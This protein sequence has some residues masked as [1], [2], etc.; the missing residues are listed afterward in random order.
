M[1]CFAAPICC[2]SSASSSDRALPSRLTAHSR[3]SDD[4]GA[5]GGMVLIYLQGDHSTWLQPPVDLVPA[6]LAAGGSLLQLPTAQAG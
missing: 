1:E 5:G 4:G 6:L 2:S 3:D